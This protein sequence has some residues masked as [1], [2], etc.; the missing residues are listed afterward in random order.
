[1]RGRK[2]FIATAGAG[3]WWFV[4]DDLVWTATGGWEQQSL[5]I[6]RW[7]WEVGGHRH[8]IRFL[9]FVKNLDA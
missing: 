1:M 8:D 6:Q 9:C 4:A 2:Y 5:V 7:W 3:S